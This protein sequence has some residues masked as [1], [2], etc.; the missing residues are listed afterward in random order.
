[1]S[2][3]LSSWAWVVFSVL[4]LAVI[5]AG[6]LWQL[7]GIPVVSGDAASHIHRSAAMQR[8][9]DL[10]VYWPRWF[11]IVY[12]DLGAPTFHHYSPGLYWLVA[13][14]HQ[15]GIGLD[16]ALKL[17]VTAVLILSSLASYGWL[18]HA[19]SP[20]AS[21]AGAA[22][23]AC[24][25]RIWPREL[26]FI[27]DYPQ[28]LGLLLLPVCLW[29]YTALH[30]EALVRNWIAAVA[31]LTL[32]VLSHNLTAMLGAGILSLS[33]LLLG[34]GYRQPA[35]LLRCA[36][37]ALLAALVTAAFWLPALA[38]TNLVQIDKART[39]YYYY[40]NHFLDWQALF[41]VH[42]P[43]LDSR[44]GDPLK[45]PVT[46]G[47]ASWIAVAAGLVSL[48][49]V[50]RAERRIWGLAGVL[51][52]L[53]M[54]IPTN[55]AS[56]PLWERIP[57]LS[58]LQ[59][60]YRFLGIAPLGALP[61]AALAV[62]AWSGRLRWLPAVGL[63]A[64]S[65]LV[66]FPYLFPA[67]TLLSP[68]T[69]LHALTAEDT[70]AL[71]HRV[72]NWGM[73]N[74]QESLVQG[75]ELDIITGKIAE[76]SATRPE[77]RTPH[78]AALNLSGQNEPML[79]R[80]HY[81][82][83]W[84]AGQSATLSA[85]PAGWMQVSGLREPGRPLVIH[86]EG[87]AAQRWGERLSLV[88]LFVSAA[89]L[90]YLAWRRHSKFSGTANR[91]E[92]NNALEEGLSSP[93]TTATMGAIVGCLLILTTV[94]L[95]LDHFGEGPFL[96]NSPPD[97]LAFSA[98]GEPIAIGDPSSSQVTLLGWH[99]L[100]RES[101]KP[102]RRV[103]VRL[104]WQPH[105]PIKEE[106]QSFL[107]LY[108]PTMQ[109]SWAVKNRGVP[110][111]D[112]QW[113]DPAKYYVDDILL[114][115]PYDLPPATYELVTGMVSSSGE[116]LPVPG[117]ADNLLRLRTL[118]VA[119]LSPGL[120]QREKPTIAARAGT[121]DG[122]RL[123]GYDLRTAPDSSTLRLFWETEDNVSADW[124]TY[125]H[126]HDVAG[127]RIAQFD[128]PALAGMVPTSKWHDNA[129]YIDRRK[130]DFPVETESGEYQLRIGL[131][132]R[133]SGER[134]RFHPEGSRESH[135]NNGQLLVPV[136]IEPSSSESN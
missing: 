54:L 1:M 129:L 52:A 2:V 42:S 98:E 83:G 82:P 18:R 94:R 101:S 11:P 127:E 108:A 78:E 136:T 8:A 123:Q 79:V 13:A 32:L 73:T 112:S 125:I 90:L 6:P 51:F 22:L 70:R 128:G 131:Y 55:S 130:L 96:L 91:V 58:F 59:F 61:A 44:A 132:N 16:V 95:A 86:W 3:R 20:A 4:M 124:I 64:V 115:L 81:H 106:L 99:L 41:A 48:P 77:W 29:A 46:F 49:F 21:L 9:F 92:R 113:W 15:T 37:A 30:R 120:T 10:G 118:D 43:I 57:A 110:R 28:L 23:F 34:A 74:T 87:T 111:P 72:R 102:G 104:Y 103:R 88:G 114:F 17:V 75:A 12:N 27:G 63:I 35:G 62:D 14:A 84:S 89:G 65:Y 31:S 47:A 126:M 25:P 85:G 60:P 134:L 33:W 36:V 76:P 53:A 116:R 40:G 39:G 71:E 69:P 67:H 68:S 56:E 80:M 66:L 135:F 100:S 50:V 109:R 97:E 122:L 24:Q 45:P 38:D 117:S 133:E 26:Y 93:S 121:D 119:P 7:P 105:G 107:H 19:F 5:I